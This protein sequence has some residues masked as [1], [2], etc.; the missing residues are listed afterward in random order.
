MRRP[1]SAVASAIAG[2]V[3]LASGCAYYNTVYNAERLFDRA[4]LARGEGRDSL[5]RELYREVAG[6]TGA[7]YGAR[8]D[9]DWAPRALVLLGRARLR[10]GELGDALAAFRE[11]EVT[12]PPSDRNAVRVYVAATL[13]EMGDEAAAFDL[14]NR[15][16]EGELEGSALAE[17]H[18][19][20]A[21]WLLSRDYVD[22]GWWDLDRVAEAQRA[23]RVE[24]GVERLRWA[25]RRGR[26]EHARVA[27]DRLLAYPEGGRSLSRVLELVAEA[28]RRWGAATAAE[29]LAATALARW[30]VGPR[31]RI[32]IERARLLHAA[33]DTAA[34]SL[35]AWAVAG[36][37]GD[38]AAE[39]RVLLA[40]WHLE[41]TQDIAEAYEV[42]RIL[43]PSGS[44]RAVAELLDAVDE[45]EALTD[46]GLAEP[47]GWFAAAEIARD[48]LGAAH[49]A[50]GLFLAYADGAPEEPWAPKA[51][52]AAAEVSLGEGDRAWLRGRLD[53]YGDSPYV[54]AARGGSGAGFEAL[55]EEL[56]LR[57]QEM[58]G[59]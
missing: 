9:S 40:G 36:T 10:L 39:A 42:R 33:G 24:A 51:L 23:L 30:E 17:A 46:V 27:A 56:G 43:L 3:L 59:R 20:R 35:Q 22:Q 25:V 32:R 5:A 38:A 55:E 41:T 12:A 21:R 7:A 50:R 18:L 45:L 8:P 57:L 6:K 58:R 31:A 11:A 13:A 16:L 14:V 53:A 2:G 37:F 15:A 28:G 29:L 48:R 54:L 26:P 19:L 47:L 49:L 4:E 52:L 34:A 1:R 44:D